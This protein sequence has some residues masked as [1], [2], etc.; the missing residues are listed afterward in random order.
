MMKKLHGLLLSKKSPPSGRIHPK[1]P[2]MILFDIN[3]KTILKIIIPSNPW[4][5]KNLRYDK[6]YPILI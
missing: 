5:V 1:L 6:I 3:L 4:W 2:V